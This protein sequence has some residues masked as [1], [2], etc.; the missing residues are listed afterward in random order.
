[1]IKF[2]KRKKKGSTQIIVYSLERFSRTDGFYYTGKRTNPE[3]Q[4]LILYFC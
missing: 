3:P 2:C 1:M 4:K